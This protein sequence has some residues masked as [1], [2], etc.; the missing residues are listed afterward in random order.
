[1]NIFFRFKINETKIKLLL[2]DIISESQLLIGSIATQSSNPVL[3]LTSN[4]KEVKV[5]EDSYCMG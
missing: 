3:G 1:M 2:Y 4:L 5:F